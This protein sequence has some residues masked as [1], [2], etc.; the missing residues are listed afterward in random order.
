MG[1]KIAKSQDDIDEEIRYASIIQ[2]MQKD[3][4]QVVSSF[5]QL[6]MSAFGESRDNAKYVPGERYDSED[7]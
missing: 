6:G 4:N 5:P 7:Y 1:Y 2:K 3:L